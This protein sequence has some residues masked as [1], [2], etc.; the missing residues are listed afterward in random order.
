[1][2]CAFGH[3]VGV[4]GA[5]EITFMNYE[6]CLVVKPLKERRSYIEQ[7]LPTILFMHVISLNILLHRDNSI[8]Q[9]SSSREGVDADGGHSQ[10]CNARP[11]T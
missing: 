5:L 8:N 11:T 1:M 10:T 4:N 9:R 3:V 2:L 7:A 6:L